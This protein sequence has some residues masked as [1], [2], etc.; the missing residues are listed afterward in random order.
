MLIVDVKRPHHRNPPCR[1]GPSALAAIALSEV[2]D[3]G[4]QES[5]GRYK[6]MGVERGFWGKLP[7]N[8]QK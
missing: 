4:P 3:Q 6:A 1:H 7:A 2:L 5:L 8:C